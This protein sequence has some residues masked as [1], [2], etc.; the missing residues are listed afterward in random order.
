MEA[1]AVGGFAGVGLTPRTA[2]G[3]WLPWARAS[4]TIARVAGE[5][6][7]RGL[8]ACDVGIVT[9]DPVADL[10]ETHAL[11]MVAAEVGAPRLVVMCRD[12]D[13]RRAAYSLRSVAQIAATAGLRV[14]LEPMPYTAVRD[15]R[16]A[17]VMLDLA[18]SPNAGILLDLY[19]HERAG[20]G[21]GDVDDDVVSRLELVQLADGTAAAPPPAELRAE[22]LSDRRYPGEGDF[23]LVDYLCRLPAEVPLTVEAPCRR[24]AVRPLHQQAVALGRATCEVLAAAGVR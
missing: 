21:P 7:A 19:Q 24:Y 22:A 12:R 6:A 17:L 5:L 16:Q 23:P 4:D 1:A 15:V 11:A 14:A 8:F 18:A 2:E 10:A 3:R 20:L 9:I 13:V